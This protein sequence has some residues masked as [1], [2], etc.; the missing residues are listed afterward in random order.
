[1]APLISAAT[2]AAAVM[3]IGLVL[4]VVVNSLPVHP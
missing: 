3:G 2:I 1:M 4:I